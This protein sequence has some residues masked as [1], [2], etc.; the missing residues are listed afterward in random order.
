MEKIIEKTSD[1]SGK[2]R[3]AEEIQILYFLQNDMYLD[4]NYVLK[5]SMEL[6]DI[7]ACEILK[8]TE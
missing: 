3:L 1:V 4:I 6:Q 7:S 2:L 8:R 5:V